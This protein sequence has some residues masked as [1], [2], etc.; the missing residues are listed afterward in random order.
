MLSEEAPLMHVVHERSLFR[1]HEIEVK[2]DKFSDLSFEFQV[3]HLF[4]SVPPQSV[5][6]PADDM[7]RGDQGKSTLPGTIHLGNYSTL[8]PVSHIDLCVLHWFMLYP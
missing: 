8:V 4:S 1:K 7:R 5:H 6:K 2:S 3:P